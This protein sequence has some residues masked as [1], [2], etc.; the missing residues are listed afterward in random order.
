MEKVTLT[1]T[2]STPMMVILNLFNDSEE[3][4]CAQIIETTSLGERE[5]KQALFSLAC[6]AYSKPTAGGILKKKSSEAGGENKKLL[7][8]AEDV[9]VINHNFNSKWRKLV[10]PSR[11]YPPRTASTKNK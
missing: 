10:I 4:S 5:V 2:V 8:A 9:F 3:L 6:V 1:V 11:P 7:I